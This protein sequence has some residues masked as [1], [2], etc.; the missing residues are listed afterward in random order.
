M[1]G[2]IKALSIMYYGDFDAGKCKHTIVYLLILGNNCRNV[3]YRATL[4]RFTE[5]FQ[6]WNNFPLN[7]DCLQE[8][9]QQI[10]PMQ[11]YIES[12]STS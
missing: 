6:L 4:G 10:Y 9:T 11:K 3:N 8:M 12:I 7:V 2:E 1:C 5:H